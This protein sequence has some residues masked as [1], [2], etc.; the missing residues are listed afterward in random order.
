[1]CV[2]CVHDPIML[3]SCDAVIAIYTGEGEGEGE[4]GGG[5]GGLNLY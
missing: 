5:V 3:E 2:I 1:M 4:G